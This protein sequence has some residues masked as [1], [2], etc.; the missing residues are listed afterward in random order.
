MNR[1]TVALPDGAQF[2]ERVFANEAGS[3]AY[4]LYVPSGYNG[5]PLPLVVML[6]GC[7]QSP[8][9]FAAGTRMNEL[10]EE[11]TFLVAYPA[12]AQSA[13]T[14]KCWNWFRE[15][16]AARPGR[17]FAYCRHHASDHARLPV[18]PGRVFM[19]VYLPEVPRLP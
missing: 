13:N 18:E 4:K 5:Q 9:D 10:A 7:T 17:A 3:R 15:R 2:E 6:H 12:Q 19:P 14:S 11:E 1:A 8:D 16:S